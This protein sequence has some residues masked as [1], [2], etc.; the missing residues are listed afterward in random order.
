MGLQPGASDAADQA[1]WTDPRNRRAGRERRDRRI[2]GVE[3]SGWRVKVAPTGR[4]GGVRG[5]AL[6]SIRATVVA[7]LAI[8]AY[9]HLNLAS[10]YG[11]TG[12]VISE[13]VLFRAEAAVALLVAISV[14]IYGR[15][16]SYAAAVLVAASALAAMLVSRYVD[17]GAVGPF[18]D[19]YD[20]VWFA[21][22][23]LSA[24]AEGVATAAG[25]AALVL[26]RSIS[27]RP[28]MQIRSRG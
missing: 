12:G 25:L 10:T 21:E 17:L 15:R 22:K 11:E 20:P 8:D 4:I 7:G 2:A 27:R 5:L 1:R 24:I 18:P 6:G 13:G 23:M 28:R 9:V 16:A 26:L 19:L 3:V 14:A